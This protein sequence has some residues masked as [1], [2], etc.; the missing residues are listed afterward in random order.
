MQASV[1][2]ELLLVCAYLCPEGHR[3]VL[4]VELESVLFVSLFVPK[5][6]L[7]LRERT[8]VS[9]IINAIFSMCIRQCSLI[10]F[11]FCTLQLTRNSA[12]YPLP[13]RTRCYVNFVTSTNAPPQQTTRVE[14]Y[15]A[16]TVKQLETRITCCW[17]RHV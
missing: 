5:E 12:S 6:S 2:K 9:V 17:G 8:K 14:R 15:S 16:P 1:L 10:L 4:S 7:L 11:Q 3:L 13:L